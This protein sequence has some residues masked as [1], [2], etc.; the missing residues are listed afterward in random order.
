MSQDRPK[1][2]DSRQDYSEVIDLMLWSALL[3]GIVVVA[4]RRLISGPT[5]SREKTVPKTVNGPFGPYIC[6]CPERAEDNVE[7]KRE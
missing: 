7:P 5:K 6:Y 2:R 3:A 4:E 1:P